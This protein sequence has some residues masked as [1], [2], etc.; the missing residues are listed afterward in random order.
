M[1]RLC[2]G[3]MGEAAFQQGLA[4]RYNSPA[5]SCPVKSFYLRRPHPGP[6]RG[7][8]LMNYINYCHYKEARVAESKDILMD[9]AERLF[10]EFGIEAVSSRQIALA[11]G[12][13]NQSAIR[14]HFGTKDDVL[15]AV[16]QSRV[17]EI[18]QRRAAL[19]AEMEAPEL[20]GLISAIAVP[21]AEKVA[22]GPQG[23]NFVRFLAHLFSDRRRRDLWL[24]EGE[25]AGLLRRIYHEIRQL[26]PEMPEALWNERLRMM[27]GEIIHSLADRERL[28]T[29]QQRAPRSLN[30]A[31]FLSNLV[32]AGVAIVTAPVSP[33][34]SRYLSSTK[35]VPTGGSNAS[36]GRRNRSHP[37]P[38]SE[39]RGGAIRTDD[40]R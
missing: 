31:A 19:L 10:A 24:T 23:S 3:Y 1:E 39:S 15:R 40:R 26:A 30:N 17:S 9:A 16:L 36:R 18:N 11:A 6:D 38:H 29:Q 20:R 13:R 28:Q 8:A 22:S 27:V 32:D 33:E 35:Q 37:Q 34:T 2:G 5:I 7:L 25:E 21:L 12:Q 14:Y 4:K